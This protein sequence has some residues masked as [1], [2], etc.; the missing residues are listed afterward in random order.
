MD[1]KARAAFRNRWREVMEGDPTKSRIYKDMG[2]GVATA[3]IEYYLPLFFDETAT[4]FDYIGQ[5]ATVALV[6]DLDSVTKGKPWGLW[7]R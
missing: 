3:G 6:G 2:N 5:D 7:A 4:V 1:D